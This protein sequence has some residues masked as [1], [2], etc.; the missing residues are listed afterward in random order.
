MGRP[1]L[2]APPRRRPDVA[3]VSPAEYR[4]MLVLQEFVL[5]PFAAAAVVLF[6]FVAV[7]AWRLA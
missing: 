1:R 3:P 4:W 7:A 2:R 6:P 5:H